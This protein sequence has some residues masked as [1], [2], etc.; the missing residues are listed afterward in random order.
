MSYDLQLRTGFFKTYR[1]KALLDQNG[2]KLHAIEPNADAEIFIA[3]E[4]VEE[5]S[6]LRVNEKLV[7]MIISGTD[8]SYVF[9]VLDLN[10]AIVMADQMR[11]EFGIK[12]YLE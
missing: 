11:N 1:C 6:F 10:K 7:E 2:I 4:S 5:V 12:V 9:R 3:W 8:T